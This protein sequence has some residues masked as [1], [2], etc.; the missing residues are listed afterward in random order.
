MEKSNVPSVR[1]DLRLSRRGGFYWLDG[2][3]YPSVTHVIGILDKPA[4]RF[5]YGREVYRAMV[6]D[7]SLSEKEA[8]NKPYEVSESAKDRG[9]TVH[10][11]VEA[12]RQNQVYL[13]NVP[14][15][16]RG[17]A[18]GFY[19]WVEDNHTEIVEHERTVVSKEH[20]YAGTLDLLIK[21]NGN[22]LPLV[23][24][25]K[26]GKGIYDEAWLQLSAYRQALAEQG[27]KTAGIAVVL[28]QDNGSYKFEHQAEDH[29]P[30]FLACKTLWEWQNREDLAKLAKYSRSNGK[31]S[32]PKNG[33]RGTDRKESTNGTLKF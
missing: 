30:Q 7:P 17:Y 11:I 6:A 10:S 9:S 19:K 13:D 5:W 2:I 26:T 25:V 23:A 21:L 24:D 29:F 33:Q 22:E 31:S 20:G 16:F 15:P 12:W 32:Q 3:P 1:S 27:V 14:E 8:L 4:L 28:L 18:Q